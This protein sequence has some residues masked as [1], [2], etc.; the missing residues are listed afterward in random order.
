MHKY[1][2]DGELM[3]ELDRPR[4]SLTFLTMA[5]WALYGYFLGAFDFS[6]YQGLG[7][8]IS[9]A[10]L[11]TFSLSILVLFS[12]GVTDDRFWRRG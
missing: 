1:D 4:I 11:I 7:D 5:G 8:S 2:V 6:A 12:R 3:P 9:I 10:L